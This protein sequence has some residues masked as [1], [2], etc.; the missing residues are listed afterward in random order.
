MPQKHVAI[1]LRR[2]PIG[3]NGC[4]EGLRAAVGLTAGTEENTV[5]CVF[6]DDAVFF[7]LRE[8]E[9]DEARKHVETLTRMDA[10]LLV[11]ETSL[12][13]RG[14]EADDVVAPFRVVPRLDIVQALRR[15][16]AS[17]GF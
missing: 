14:L 17:L 8:A 10:P 13:M 1:T 2:S 11:D 9:R 6:L 4:V 7:T 5:T 16:D 12:G 3:T 15:A